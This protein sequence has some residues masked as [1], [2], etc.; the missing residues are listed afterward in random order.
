MPA[1]SSSTE[2]KTSCSALLAATGSV[3]SKSGRSGAAPC[4]RARRA[5]GNRPHLTRPENPRS[6]VD[7]ATVGEEP[8]AEQEVLERA[9]DGE[10]GAER[11]R[12]RRELAC[13]EHPAID[14][15]QEETVVAGARGK[16]QRARGLVGDDRDEVVGAPVEHFERRVVEA[17]EDV[18]G[19]RASC[20]EHRRSEHGR[21][22]PVAGA[23]RGDRRGADHADANARAG[24]GQLR[25]RLVTGCRRGQRVEPV[26][27]GA[28]GCDEQMHSREDTPGH[29][30]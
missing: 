16:R 2:Q 27:R 29:S 1:C 19:E 11:G 13:D 21:G 15:G 22:P 30:G 8:E 9:V 7:R 10:L 17:V 4:T 5:V 23:A 28:G 12:E 26:D 24:L 18:L 20:S 3:T 25:P 14:L 6:V